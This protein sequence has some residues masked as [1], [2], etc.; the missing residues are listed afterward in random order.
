MDVE[1]PATLGL[2][3][4]MSPALRGR[5]LLIRSRSHDTSSDRTLA[6]ISRVNQD[7][8]AL[9]GPGETQQARQHQ[10]IAEAVATMNHW[11]VY[12]T[13]DLDV[14]MRRQNV[15][16]GAI[17]LGDLALV[18]DLLETRY[19]GLVDVN[20]ESF[21]FGRPLQLAAAWG[22][23]AIVAYLLRR[24]ADP[25]ALSK[26]SRE[27]G[28]QDYSSG[29]YLSVGPRHKYRS[30]R[31]SA[32]RA[33]ALAG[34]E[35]IVHLLLRPENRLSPTKVEFFRALLATARND[36][37]GL[38]QLL[39]REAGRPE[40]EL[41]CVREWMFWEACLHGRESM[42]QMLLDSGVDVDMEVFQKTP[43]CSGL[44]IAAAQGK[45]HMVRFLLDHGADA[46][47]A[48]IWD[49]LPIRAAAAG[50]HDDVVDLLLDRG[51][52]PIL[53]LDAAAGGGQARMVQLILRRY[54][55]LHSQPVAEG[56][57]ETVGSSA[58]RR[59]IFVRNPTIITALVDAGVSPNEC[60][61]RGEYPVVWAKIE[62]ARWIVDHLVSL[63]AE[64]VGMA[65]PDSWYEPSE[66]GDLRLGIRITQR[67]WEWTGKY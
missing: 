3:I 8:D 52:S 19:R 62:G 16:S 65:G 34:H 18:A 29:T 61:D 27:D 20:A 7:L 38:A 4:E 25:R 10:L 5:I 40:T 46:N 30:P 55:G 37:P 32:L 24:G 17:V 64:D 12:G 54:P 57:P 15:F 48:M 58:L 26:D 44:S 23:L 6:V 36:Q 63:G 21:F 42:A 11:K 13:P 43:F 14:D 41:A 2:S 66:D 22:H 28:N 60:F 49:G 59:G 39:L 53:A 33:A 9:T 51:A 45:L 1:D 56:D 50:G 35:D 67:T 47:V 31:G